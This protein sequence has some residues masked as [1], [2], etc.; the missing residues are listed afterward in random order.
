MSDLANAI[1]NA[2]LEPMKELDPFFPIDPQENS[3]SDQ[4]R[5]HITTPWETYKKLE[6]LNVSKAPGTDAIPNFV[7][8]EFA[9]ILTCLISNLINCSFSH[10]FLPSLWK[11]ANVIPVPKEKVVLD[12]NK[13]LRPISLICCLAKMAEEFVI[14][15]FVGPAI[16]KH[17]D[18]V[19]SLERPQP[20]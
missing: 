4:P 9:E 13:H 19:T 14:E 1:N 5:D 2:F 10:Q 16:L 20:C 18:P 6:S 8:K 17:I 12:V 15:K 11:L 3:I 7:Y